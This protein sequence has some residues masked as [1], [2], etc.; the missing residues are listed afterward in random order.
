MG[1]KSKIEKCPVQ[2]FAE[3]LVFMRLKTSHKSAKTKHVK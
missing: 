2:I 1:V 3:N